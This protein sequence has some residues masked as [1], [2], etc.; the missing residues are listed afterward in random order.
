MSE[1]PIVTICGSMRFYEFMLQRAEELTAEGKIVLM[2][3]VT[4]SGRPAVSPEMLDEMHRRKID[5]SS[6]IEVI[7]GFTGYVGQSTAG[8]I[9]YARKNDKGVTYR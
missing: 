7:T 5:L 1:Y 8:E 2:P 4:K 9:E 3:F 6:E